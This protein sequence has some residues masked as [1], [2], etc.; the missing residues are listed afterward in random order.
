MKY[1]D[2]ITIQKFIE[3]LIEAFKYE[4]THRELK[5]KKLNI[6]FLV[7]ALW[8]DLI[9]NYEHYDEFCSDLRD[10]GDY[11]IV[12]EDDNYCTCKACVGFFN[13]IMEALDFGYEIVFDFDAR[14]WG[15][16]ECNPSDL[17][18]REDK[19][20]CGHGCDWDAPSI[21]VRKSF[22]VSNHSWNGDEHDYWDLKISFMQMI[23]KK[24]KRN[25]WQR[26]NIRLRVLKKPLKML[27][28][29]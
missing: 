22:L 15:Y 25:F 21:E 6:P 17:D 14:Y 3:E 9:S 5:G 13:E 28:G 19:H 4:N 11:N 26:E 29:N 12:I 10:C 7:S 2:N 23:K 24:K 27:R 16:C 20:C 18:Y 1:S 8:Q